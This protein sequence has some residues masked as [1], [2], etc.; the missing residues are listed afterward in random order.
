MKFSAQLDVNV[1]AHETTD[2]VVVLLDLEAPDLVTDEDRAPATFQVVLD[3]SGSMDDLLPSA[4]QALEAL[5]SRLDARDNFG[6]VVFD[7]TAEI[8]VP[9]G[10]VVDKERIVHLLRQIRVGGMTD[11]GAGL[12]RGLQEVRRVGADASTL[13]IVS[14]GHTNA[15]VTDLDALAGVAAQGRGHGVVTSTLGLGLGYD[16][17]LLAGLARSGA[18]NHV[19]AEGADQAGAAIAAE[20]TGLLSK[21]VQAATLTMTFHDAVEMLRVYNDLPGHQ[22]APGVVMLEIG[23][24]YA[25]ERRKLLLKLRVPAMAALG[26]AQVAE[27]ELRYVELPQLVEQVVTLPITVNVV[28]GDQAAGRVP[29]PV[30]RSEV[31]F[32]EAQDDKLAASKALER[33]DRETATERLDAARAKLTEA[34]VDAPEEVLADL[35]EELDDVGTFVTGMQTHDSA[36]TSKMTRDS[37]YQ[38]RYKRGRRRPQDGGTR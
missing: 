23:D 33:G 36:Y 26:L 29:D 16:E 31:L 4:I 37:F 27:L 13:L 30:V 2:E 1:V 12:L 19:F 35:R 20:A 10:P 25:G 22:L 28:P 3:R 38:S 34:G 17:T 9:S 24:L 14:D 18:G 21:T 15:G 6:V 32:Q 7:D 11:L 8:A 5:V